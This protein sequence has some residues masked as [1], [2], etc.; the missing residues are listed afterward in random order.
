MHD[1]RTFATE[2]PTLATRSFARALP[3][4][5]GRDTDLSAVC[6]LI[7]DEVATDL[8]LLELMLHMAGASDVHTITDART[9]VDRYLEIRPDL[10]LMDLDMGT[11]SGHGVVTSLREVPCDEMF[12]PVVVL[13]A[14]PTAHT[15]VRAFAAGANDLITKP[16]DQVEMIGRM[17]NLLTM[18][19]LYRDVRRHN[20]ELHPDL[21]SPAETAISP[22]GRGCTAPTLA[23]GDIGG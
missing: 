6:L 5:V 21:D 14:D 1:Q 22:L 10:V 23:V 9:A 13:T 2:P 3:Q 18:R 16:Y 19:K 11:V 17:R 7:V 8:R 15:R 4:D 20:V 12:L